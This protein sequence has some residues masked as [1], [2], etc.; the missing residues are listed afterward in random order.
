MTLVSVDKAK[1]RTGNSYSYTQHIEDLFNVS[2]L[3]KDMT[4]NI[5]G[6]VI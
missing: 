2:L 3:C 4:K 1:T 6:Q 5:T